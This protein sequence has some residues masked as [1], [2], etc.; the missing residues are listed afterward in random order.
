MHAATATMDGSCSSKNDASVCGSFEE[1]DS[2]KL[3]DDPHLFP[4]LTVAEDAA[5]NNDNTPIHF[6]LFSA[7]LQTATSN[8]AQSD[9]LIYGTSLVVTVNLM[10]IS[11]TP[12][13]N[14]V[15]K[16]GCEQRRLAD[17]L[18]QRLLD[19]YYRIANLT[20]GPVVDGVCS[21]AISGQLSGL[22]DHMGMIHEVF[23]SGVR[24]LDVRLKTHF[25]NKNVF[26]YY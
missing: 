25:R 11:Y 9:S 4:F 19:R 3:A 8:F 10:Q 15:T 23:W 1:S 2:A 20:T 13:Q 14:W 18:C 16:A 5:S 22:K 24:G 26:F 6:P 21:N 12:L 17:Y 7:A